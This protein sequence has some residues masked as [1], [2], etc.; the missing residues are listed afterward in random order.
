M[1]RSLTLPLALLQLI[2]C[3]DSF[4]S[5]LHVAARVI[6]PSIIHPIHDGAVCSLRSF[7]RGKDDAPTFLTAV[8]SRLCSTVRIP[9][10]ETLVIGSRLNMTGLRD[11]RIVS[12]F[13]PYAWVR[14]K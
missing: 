4:T 6:H 12:L 9:K 14:L 7:G 1:K 10:G 11:K 13:A 5:L 3:I 8:H 2:L